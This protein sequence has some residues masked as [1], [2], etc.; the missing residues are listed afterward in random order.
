MENWEYLSILKFSQYAA[1]PLSKGGWPFPGVNFASKG[2]LLLLLTSLS[3][4]GKIFRISH[5]CTLLCQKSL[6]EVN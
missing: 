5:L 4:E 3:L 6:L 2:F 1:A